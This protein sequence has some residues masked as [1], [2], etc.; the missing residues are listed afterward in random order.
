M[1]K[2]NVGYQQTELFGFEDKLT[3]K[4]SLYLHNSMSLHFSRSVS[5][6]R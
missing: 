3:K 4:Q 5:K 2:R 6:D 1:F